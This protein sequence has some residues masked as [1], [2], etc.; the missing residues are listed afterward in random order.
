M[1]KLFELKILNKSALQNF[2]FHATFIDVCQLCVGLIKLL[3]ITVLYT[4][5]NILNS[6][7]DQ[8]HLRNYNASAALFILVQPSSE[9]K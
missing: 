7:I 5:N 3:W 2:Q 8:I 6:N 1:Y 9:E 4:T